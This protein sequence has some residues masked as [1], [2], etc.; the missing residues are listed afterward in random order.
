MVA[1]IVLM[2]E[3]GTGLQMEVSVLTWI[4]YKSLP[5]YG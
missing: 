3:V 1:R 5:H 2:C 4:L